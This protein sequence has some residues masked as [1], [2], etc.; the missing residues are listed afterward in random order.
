MPIEFHI[1]ARTGSLYGLVTKVFNIKLRPSYQLNIFRARSAKQVHVNWSFLPIMLNWHILVTINKV[2]FKVICN[3]DLQLRSQFKRKRCNV[4]ATKIGFC[5][6]AASSNFYVM[7]I[8]HALGQSSNL[9]TVGIVKTDVMNVGGR[10]ILHMLL[11]RQ[12][13]QL[14]H[15]SL[16]RQR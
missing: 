15:W 7:S 10:V 3:R 1:H 8:L 9:D 12:Y 16:S 14:L 13:W 5:H 6:W 2:L 4:P 11:V